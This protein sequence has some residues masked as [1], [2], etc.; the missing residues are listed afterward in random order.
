[1]GHPSANPPRYTAN[2]AG[3]NI[4]ESIIHNSIT[5]TATISLVIQ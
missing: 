1:M 3:T 2:I 5:N 4:R